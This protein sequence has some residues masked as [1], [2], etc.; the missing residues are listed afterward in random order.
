MYGALCV[1]CK[2]L[3]YVH[4]AFLLCFDELFSDT[5]VYAVYV[6]YLYFTGTPI[7]G[8]FYLYM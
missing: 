6:R 8:T 5:L 2:V 3:M 4:K 1:A 7:H